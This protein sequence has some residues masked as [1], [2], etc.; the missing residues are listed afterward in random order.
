MPE[1]K[2]KDTKSVEA[3]VVATKDVKKDTVKETAKTTTKDASK[4]TAP[5]KDTSKTTAPTKATTAV[6]ETSKSSAPAKDTAKKTANK[7]KA[8][9]KKKVTDEESKP[10]QRSFK[11][12]FANP[13]GKVVMEGRFCGVKPKQAACK[14]LTGIYKTFKNAGKDSDVK[15]EVKFGVYETTRNSKNKKYWYSGKKQE[16]ETPICLYQIPTTVKDEDGKEKKKYCSA[17]QI[18]QQ[19]GFEKLFGSKQSN[20]K[21]AIEYNF[22]N[23]VSK[24]K[25][26]DECK[27]LFTVDIEIPDPESSS[28]SAPVATKT[29]KKSDKVAEPA[30]AVKA[31]TGKSSKSDDKSTKKNTDKAESKPAEKPAEKAA[32]KAAEKPV[33]K[34]AEKAADKP[35]EKTADKSA[36]KVTD[37]KKSK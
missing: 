27:H 14:A 24:V 5:T 32:E 33:E 3:P 7:K 18:E 10:H 31:D 20:I 2:T 16:L 13:D 36:K 8:D 6:K 11:V 35:A 25:D 19:G 34:P 21:P 15:N 9:K 28:T 29:S 30:K 1:K 17:A 22:T 4:T 23:V 37:N 12:I 26:A